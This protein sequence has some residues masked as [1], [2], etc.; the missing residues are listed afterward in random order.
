MTFTSWMDS[1]VLRATTKPSDAPALQASFDALTILDSNTKCR[2][3]Y[4]SGPALAA[5]P[6]V[7]RPW[8]RETMTL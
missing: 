3:F 6:V 4:V 8:N 1:V 2:G 7:D 5:H